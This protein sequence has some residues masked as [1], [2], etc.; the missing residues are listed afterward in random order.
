M[1]RAPYHRYPLWCSFLATGFFWCRVYGYG[2]VVKDT[3]IHPLLFSQRMGITW[4][5]RFGP[6]VMHFLTPNT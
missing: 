2:F 6:H 5:F 3:R 1:K 4:F